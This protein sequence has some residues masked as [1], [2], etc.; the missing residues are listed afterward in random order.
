M[1]HLV[2]AAVSSLALA[3]C[4]MSGQDNETGEETTATADAGSDYGYDTYGEDNLADTMASNDNAAM[5]DSAQAGENA[6][7]MGQQSGED[8][9]PDSEKILKTLKQAIRLMYPEDEALKIE[10][11]VRRGEGVVKT[12]FMHAFMDLHTF[13]VDR[14]KKCCTHYA[15]PDGRLMPGCAY[16]L[17][18]RDK[19]P[20][21]G[22]EIGSAKIWGEAG[23]AAGTRLP[24]ASGE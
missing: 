19:D 13:E 9:I 7:N 24:V 1:R 4:S 6:S 11:R 5:R 10:E 23:P 17:F 20:R 15:M 3:A 2:F 8:A 16:N 21:F 18:Y 12:I 14:I 22:G